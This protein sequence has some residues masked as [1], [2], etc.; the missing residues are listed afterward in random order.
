MGNMKERSVHVEIG[1]ETEVEIRTGLTH[2]VEDEDI[3]AGHVIEIAGGGVDHVIAR[4]VDRGTGIEIR[5]ETEGIE[6]EGIS[7]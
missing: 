4:E 5:I 2:Q 7:L 3:V 6:D 1:I